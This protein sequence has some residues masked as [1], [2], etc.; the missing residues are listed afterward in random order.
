VAGTLQFGI[1][2]ANIEARVVN[3]EPRVAD[4]GEKSSAISRKRRFVL[5]KFLRTG[6]A[7]KGFGRNVPFGIE[8]SGEKFGRMESD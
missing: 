6:R 5:E 1:E 7:P 4:K 3:D 2:E 8:G